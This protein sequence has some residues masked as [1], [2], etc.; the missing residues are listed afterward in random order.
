MECNSSLAIARTKYEPKIAAALTH[1]SEIDFVSD[2]VIDIDAAL[3]KHFPYL[4]QSTQLKISLENPMPSK[5]LRVGVVLSGGQAAGG[6]NVIC[7]LFDALRQIHPDSRL[8]GFLNGPS[9]IVQGQ[10]KELSKE[11]L[12]EYRN[13]GGFDVIGSGRT[14]IETQEQFLKTCEHMK[15]LSLDG[16]VIIG[17]DDSNTNAAYLAEY[18]KAH[19]VSTTVVGV[20]KTIDGD[21]QNEI[22]RISFGFDTACKVYSEI[23]GNIAR[24]ALSNKKYYFFVKLMGRSA[25]HITLECALR[26]H[27]NLAFIGE[28]IAAQKKTLA[29]IVQE[30][31][32]LICER[33]KIGLEYGVILIPE[34]LIEFMCDVKILIAELNQLLS[35]EYQHLSKIQDIADPDKKRSY[36]SD[37]LTPESKRCYDLFPRLIQLQLLLDR[38]PHGNVQVSK[39]ET[40][41]LLMELVKEKIHALK[42][43]GNFKGNFSAQGIFCGYE[44]RS[45]MPSNFDSDYCYNLGL[46]AAILTVRK[47]SGYMAALNYLDKPVMEWEPKPVPLIQLLHFEM[48]NG[49][50]KAVI[51]KT[52]VDLEGKPF[53][54]WKQ[55][56]ADFRLN[57]DYI[58]PG[59][60]QFFGPERL[61][62]IKPLTVINR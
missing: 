35:N 42:H 54:L 31:I 25:S 18:F 62:D 7:G 40:D 26:T 16:L 45:A 21:L 36:I 6:H 12:A 3:Q 9:G 51:A 60:I 23:I 19:D 1:F 49:V 56:R 10:Y 17:G 47:L 41:Q 5:P 30:I 32:E 13:Q 14:K 11:V 57:D 4:K 52:L 44:G 50:Q 27:P 22:V 34:G 39:I 53:K 61:T 2:G 58:Q 38:D 46:T 55:N 59:P 29:D 37:F 24:D 15:A 8:F 20:P 33:S 28:E 43:E 48:R